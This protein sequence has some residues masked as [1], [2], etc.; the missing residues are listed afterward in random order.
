MDK[1]GQ[2]RMIYMDKMSDINGYRIGYGWISVETKGE[3]SRILMD[4]KSDIHG[5]RIGY[6]WI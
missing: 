3:N 2:N 6:K 5:Y 4:K 1:K